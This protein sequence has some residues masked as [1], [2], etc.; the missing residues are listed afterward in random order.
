MCFWRAFPPS[1]RAQWS[2]YQF[3]NGVKQALQP[4]ILLVDDICRFFPLPLQRGL[5]YDGFE[6]I[7][8]AVDASPGLGP[9]AKQ[10]CNRTSSL[11]DIACPGP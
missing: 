5:A 2:C 10:Q 4:R 3:H 6:V 9:A 11:L 8:P 7:H 1:V